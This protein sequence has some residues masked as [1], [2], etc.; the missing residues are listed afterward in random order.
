MVSEIYERAVDPLQ[1]DREDICWEKEI[2]LRPL[3]RN[4]F[5][6]SLKK[7]DSKWV[8]ADVLDIGCGNGWLMDLL[9]K[10]KA[11]SVE[12][13]E[14]SKKNIILL[15][16]EFPHL[17]IINCDF[18][19]FETEKKYDLITGV[20]VFTHFSDLDSVFRKIYNLLKEDGE[21]HAIIPDYEYTKKQRKDYEILIEELNEDE[22][23]IQIKKD[24]GVIADIVRKVEVYEKTGKKNGMM[25]MDNVG[26]SCSKRLK[27]GGNEVIFH[28]LRFKKF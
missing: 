24:F 12:G 3:T 13:L 22:Y 16:K 26:V 1:Y 11:R 15:K 6:D 28:L 7:Y 2:E 4:L 10:D 21:L 20:M 18:Q 8:N 27:D 19:S 25:L 17:D 9:I 14:P 23:V 5:F